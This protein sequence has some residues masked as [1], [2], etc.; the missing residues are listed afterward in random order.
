MTAIVNAKEAIDILERAIFP[1]IFFV[2]NFF[3]NKEREREVC[4]KNT[5]N[6]FFSF[7]K[8]KKKGDNTSFFKNEK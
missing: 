4:A 1:R 6:V 7:D 5:K 3:C 2:Y 8:K